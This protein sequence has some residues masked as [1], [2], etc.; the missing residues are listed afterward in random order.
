M[1]LIDECIYNIYRC[2][3]DEY[4]LVVFAE[5]C[6]IYEHIYVSLNVWCYKCVNK[7]TIDDITM[8][9]CCMIMMGFGKV[10]EHNNHTL[11][12]MELRGHAE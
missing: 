9:E 1:A 3:I 10:W 4:V 8:T 5:P 2:V 7:A 6:W 12:V 11:N